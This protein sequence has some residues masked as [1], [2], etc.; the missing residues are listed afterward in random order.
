[1]VKASRR[2]SGCP[3]F[4][5]RG[6]VLLAAHLA[7]ESKP[8]HTKELSNGTFGRGAVGPRAFG[9]GASGPEGFGTWTSAFQPGTLAAGEGSF[10]RGGRRGHLH[11]LV[12][13]HGA[14]GR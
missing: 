4:V 3:W 14:G 1:M 9:P 12:H 6:R 2:V 7:T 5:R 10:A 11:E 8:H 13:P